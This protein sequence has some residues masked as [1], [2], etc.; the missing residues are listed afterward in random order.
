M[1]A[2]EH[3]LSLARTA[4]LAANEKLGED[5]AVVDVSEQLVITDCFVL[6]TGDNERHVNALID[7]IEDDLRDAGAKPVRREGARE[8]RWALLDYGD[9]VV[10]VFRREEREFYGLDRLWRDCPLVEVDGI[11]PYVRRDVA[12]DVDIRQVTSIDEIPLVDSDPDAGQL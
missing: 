11:D 9:I 5:I 4:A 10:H 3:S 12:G 8:G 2:S 7:E 1:T 6:V